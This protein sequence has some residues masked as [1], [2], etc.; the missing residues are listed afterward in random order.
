MVHTIIVEVAEVG[1]VVKGA[2]VVELANMYPPGRRL[3][4]ASC[5]HLLQVVTIELQ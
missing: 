1:Q 2:L 4:S 5:I 3:F